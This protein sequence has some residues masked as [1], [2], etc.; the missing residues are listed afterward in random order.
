MCVTKTPR[1]SK[2]GKNGSISDETKSG[3]ITGA[4]ADVF[5]ALVEGAKKKNQLTRA[6]LTF[7]L[8]DASAMPSTMN[9]MNA[10]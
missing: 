1:L 9:D 4:D 2:G 3:E 6:E 10:F 5:T 7:P 8:R